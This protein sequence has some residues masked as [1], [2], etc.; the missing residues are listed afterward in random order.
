MKH[1]LFLPLIILISLFSN[2]KTYQIYNNINGFNNY[3]NLNII[4]D[5]KN[6]YDNTNIIG[7]IKIEGTNIND[8]IAKSNDNSFYLNHS[9]YN[10]ENIVGS[11]FMDYRNNIED[12]QI[13]I[14]AHSGNILKAPFNDLKNYLN[15]DFFKTNNNIKLITDKY[16]KKYI[17]FSVIIVKNNYEHMN[18]N[19]DD[20]H[21]NYFINNS[22][23]KTD[24]NVSSDDNL[25]VLQT[26]L[27]KDDAY[28]VV[29]AKE[30]KEE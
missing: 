29:A 22:I 10:T 9:L 13:N 30:L 16:V 24:I 4:D 11:I 20:N 5:I 8:Y 17:I 25:L 14:Y 23:F 1:I 6:Y 7:M 3:N 18:L 21:I 2:N 26:C 28:I 15:E 12:K 19:I 27:L